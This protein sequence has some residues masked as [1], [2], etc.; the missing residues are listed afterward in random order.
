MNFQKWEHFS[1]SPGKFPAH[2]GRKRQLEKMRG[3]DEGDFSRQK[4]RPKL[5]YL[6]EGGSFRHFPLNP[7]LS[8]IIRMNVMLLPSVYAA[9]HVP[10]AY[11]NFVT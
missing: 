9:A 7:P 3:Q 1:G 2:S 4:G 10:T 11:C 8:A 6:R 5:S